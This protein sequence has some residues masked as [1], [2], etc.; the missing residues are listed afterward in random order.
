MESTS[1]QDLAPANENRLT[2]F[3]SD[4]LLGKR[5]RLDGSQAASNNA[6][7]FTPSAQ[8][9]RDN[10]RM[11]TDDNQ[12]INGNSSSNAASASTTTA[13]TV[14][15]DNSED[16][17]LKKILLEAFKV[18]IDKKVLSYGS[19]CDELYNRQVAV[20]TLHNH[21][22]NNTLPKDLCFNVQTGNPYKKTVSN[23]DELLKREQQ[24]LQD[25][26]LQILTIRQEV[27][28]QEVIRLQAKCQEYF[29]VDAIME[30]LRQELSSGIQ[31]NA[32]HLSDARASY[33][34]AINQKR[35]NMES[36]VAKKEASY[37]RSLQRKQKTTPL[38]ATLNEHQ[39]KTSM[40][41]FLQGY[42][43]K[44]KPVFNKSLPSE[45]KSATSA[46]AHYDVRNPP[47]K[48]RQGKRGKRTGA[49][50]SNDAGTTT[51]GTLSKQSTTGQDNSNNRNTHNK[52]TS[53]INAHPALSKPRQHQ[54]Q[55]PR[56]NS[57]QNKQQSVKSYASAV[58]SRRV[59]YQ[60]KNIIDDDNDDDDDNDGYT[61]VTYIKPRNNN[62]QHNA[63]NASAS[64]PRNVPKQQRR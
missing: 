23:R 6:S 27:A 37:Q 42:I 16:S 5:S 13:A 54:Q 8:L 10:N 19:D 14:T 45:K 28:K 53:N 64:D 62:H 17:L 31:L 43:N 61:K 22:A 60:D 48:K 2:L 50:S 3:D 29:N 20:R 58:Q 34:F 24:I 39:F 15:T 55:P 32:S 21:A 7:N 33:C 38:T 25:A 9:L 41:D 57:Q 46:T 1:I 35:V 30:E 4:S 51:R 11:D 49:S 36:L 40:V 56:T 26:K 44:H 59:V 52:Q 12:Q 63:K 18:F 47:H